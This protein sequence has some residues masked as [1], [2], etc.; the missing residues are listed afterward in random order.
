[1][2]GM[3]KALPPSIVPGA[4][5]QPTGASKR[6]RVAATTPILT[7]KVGPNSHPQKVRVHVA[8]RDESVTEKVNE[9]EQEASHA[10]GNKSVPW[11]RRP[12]T[13]EIG[14]VH[15]QVQQKKC[16][17]CNETATSTKTSSSKGMRTSTAD[18]LKACSRCEH[19]LCP[20]CVQLC[21]LC[22]RVQCTCCTVMDYDST[23]TQQTVCLDCFNDS[24]GA[25]LSIGDSRDV[26]GDAVMK[27]S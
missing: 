10:S 18:D 23:V 16:Y 2:A 15:P 26:D 7:S 17:Y 20:S 9:K 3:A 4:E 8:L 19:V 6:S 25:A 24:N 21:D 1:M 13:A 14:Q 11:W 12:N 5:L 27:S 22:A